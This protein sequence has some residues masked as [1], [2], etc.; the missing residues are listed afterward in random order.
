MTA[1]AGSRAS[2]R[3]QARTRRLHAFRNAAARRASVAVGGPARIRVVGLLSLVLALNSADAS[4]VGAAAGPIKQALHIDYTQLGLLVALPALIGAA[5]T[6]P[7]GALTD[8]VRRVRLLAGSLVLWSASMLISGASSSYRMLLASQM[9]VGAVTATSGPTIAS[10]TGDFF[11]SRERGRIY[12]FI[13]TGELLGSVIGLFISGNAAGVLSWR[14]AFWVLAI[15]SAVLAWEI[16]RLLPEPARAGQ[17]RLAPGAAQ[18]PA[19]DAPPAPPLT[20]GPEQSRGDPGILQREIAAQHVPPRTELVL[21]DDPGEMNLWQAVRYVLHVPTNLALITVSSLGYFFQSGVQT[22]AVIFVGHQYAVGQALATTLLAILAV[23]AIV[24]VLASGRIAD[25]LV[26]RGHIA[27]RVL[28]AAIALLLAAVLFLPPLLSRSLLIGIP[29]LLL[30]TAA[31][32]ATNPPLDA[33]RLDIMPARLWG[34]AEGVR[35]LLRSVAQAFAPLLFGFVSD[36]LSTGTRT[37]GQHTGLGQQAQASGLRDTF[38][39]ML[40]PLAIG[41][42]ILLRSTGVYR[43]DVATALASEQK[44]S[45]R[46]DAAPQHR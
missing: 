5:A 14:F 27:G 36:Q 4:A 20:E 33:A 42:V 25:Q 13:L 29:F 3:R 12:S 17:S 26:E 2:V 22:F 37:A 30:A 32:S 31:L 6:V 19:T 43:R 21:E 38:L 1:G 46:Q 41:G 28:V 9:L 44:P 39:I 10:L 15:P 11:P 24:G 8:R 18:L 16:W 45:S 23:G 40:I 35:T 7:V 34:R